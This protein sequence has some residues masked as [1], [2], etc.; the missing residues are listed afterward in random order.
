M[1][2]LSRSAAADYGRAGIRINVL[3]PG[4][5]RTDILTD[6]LEEEGALEHMQSLTP[7][8]RIVEP[9]EVGPLVAWMLSDASCFM[10]GSVVIADGGYTAI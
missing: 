5:V 10:T 7:Q 2:G 1:I 4:S 3:A 6:W 8:G 9:E